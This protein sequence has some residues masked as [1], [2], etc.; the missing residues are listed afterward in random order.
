MIGRM[1][2]AGSFFGF[3]DPPENDPI[4]GEK[5]NHP[6]KGAKRYGYYDRSLVANSTEIREPFTT[7]RDEIHQQNYDLMS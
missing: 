3:M 7:T 5:R 4:P 6:L 2:Q 1:I